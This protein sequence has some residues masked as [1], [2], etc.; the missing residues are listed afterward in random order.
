MPTK[1][2]SAPRVMASS[3][4]YPV[5]TDKVKAMLN[6]FDDSY[7]SKIE[8]VIADAFVEVEN[9]IEQSLYSRRWRVTFGEVEEFV[10]LTMGPNFDIV[11]VK[12]LSGTDIAYT[13]SKLNQKLY[14]DA[15]NGAQ[16]EYNGGYNT[17]T[18]LVPAPIISA[19]VNLACSKFDKSIAEQESDWKS[20]KKQLSKYRNVYV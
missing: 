11:F 18:S 14:F 16:I 19:I 5:I 4:S 15:P 9:Y 2:R 10:E 3:G 1:D 17:T 6:I 8:Y 7:D 13:A 12:D 20:I